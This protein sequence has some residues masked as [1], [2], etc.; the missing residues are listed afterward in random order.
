MLRAWRKRRALKRIARRLPRDLSRRFGATDAYT[1]DQVKSVLR[2][3]RYDPR[4]WN[5]AL[6][7]CLLA[8]SAAAEVG[9]AA[10]VGN[11]RGELG[12]RFFH[13][14]AGFS[15]D[16]ARLDAGSGVAHG[17]GDVYSGGG[18]HDPG[19]GGGGFGGDGGSL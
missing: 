3:G 9:G 14:D 16:S 13:G 12:D 19:G 18:F 17:H 8:D 5:Y 11:L 15:L 10:E 1:A 4:Y 7:M 6:A 2:D